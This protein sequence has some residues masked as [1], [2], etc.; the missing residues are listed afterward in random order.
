MSHTGLILYYYISLLLLHIID[1]AT[2]NF[3]SNQFIPPVC[4]T[5]HTIHTETA[6]TEKQSE[7]YYLFFINFNVLLLIN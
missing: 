3:S 1:V 2:W 7:Y 6:P 5:T 4:M